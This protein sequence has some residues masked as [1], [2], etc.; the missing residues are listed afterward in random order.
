MSGTCGDKS[1][2]IIGANLLKGNYIVIYKW[3]GSVL[4]EKWQGA[5]GTDIKQQEQYWAQ[6]INQHRFPWTE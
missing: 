2:I 1:S 3:N 6:Q 4:V 5:P